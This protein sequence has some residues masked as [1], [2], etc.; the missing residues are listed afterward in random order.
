MLI[1]KRYSLI[2]ML[3]WTRWETYFFIIMS[4]LSL[5]LY[6]YFE[7][8]YLHL[9]WTPIALIGTAVAFMV[10]FQNSAAYGRIWEAREIWANIASLSRSWGIIVKDLVLNENGKNLVQQNEIDRHIKKLIY[11]HIA[12]LTSLRHSMR[13]KRMWEVFLESKT[14]REWAKKIYVPEFRSSLESDLKN[15]LTKNEIDYVLKKHNPSSTIISLQSKHL[16]VLKEQSIFQELSFVKLENILIELLNH[17]SH[18][19]RIKNFPYPRQ[20]ATLNNLFVKIFIIMLPFGIIPEFDKIGD[21]FRTSF[22]V[23][24]TYFIWFAIPFNVIVS[25]VFHTM[26]RIG[27]V[28]ENPFEGSAYTEGF[29]E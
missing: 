19:E 26:E 27:K 23:V 8:K 15:F 4:L 24:S 11:R 22:P 10:G 7:M 25:W 1:K 20:Y 28:G 16:K 6:E 3:L 14:N 29:F 5:I 17:Q 21:Y 9:P 13:Q 2:D 18:T 12:W